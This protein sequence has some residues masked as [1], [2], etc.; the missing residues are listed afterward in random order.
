MGGRTEA[1]TTQPL[2]MTHSKRRGRSGTEACEGWTTDDRLTNE[3]AT[4]RTFLLQ[5]LHS[6]SHAYAT[7][8]LPLPQPLRNT[9]L[10]NLVVSVAMSSRAPPDP[11]KRA[12]QM[13]AGSQISNILHPIA[14]V[15]KGV[16]RTNHSQ[17][18]RQAL[19]AT[20]V[21]NA[22]KREEEEA[23]AAEEPFKMARFRG[24]ESV[25]RQKSAEGTLGQG[26][27]RSNGDEPVSRRTVSSG[28]LTAKMGNLS[29][30]SQ[31]QRRNGPASAQRGSAP[32]RAG[33]GTSNKS[34]TSA[35]P[36][37]LQ[38]D[39]DE[40]ENLYGQQ[41]QQQQQYDDEGDEGD[42]SP[43]Q[44][45]DDE[46]QDE[47][48][49]QYGRQSQQQQPQYSSQPQGGRRP[50]QQQ[51]APQ[52][53]ED[54]ESLNGLMAGRT[55]QQQGYGGGN[56]GPPRGISSIR[57]PSQQHQQQQ[58]QYQQP[59]SQQSHYSDNS[60]NNGDRRSF[61]AENAKKVI[62]TSKQLASARSNHPDDYA[63]QQQGEFLSSTSSSSA[64]GSGGGGAGGGASIQKHNDYG[65]VPQYIQDG[66]ARES[67]RRAREAEEESRKALG[68]PEGM[69]LMGEEQRL[70]T[71]AVLQENHR[72]ILLEISAFPLRVETISRKK[73]K[74]DLEAKLEEI[75][76]ALQ[77]FSRKR[78]LIQP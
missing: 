57:V 52:Y 55:Q 11:R 49:Q 10:A 58:Q 7:P 40:E 54:E 69:V 51:Q 1:S 6:L 73:A 29:M 22:L 56:G 19:K 59:P 13:N 46:E 25:L 21:R 67:E 33:A 28:G 30:S 9:P 62:Q 76:K 5:L 16:V 43:R 38:Y 37:R 78:V 32:P 41:Q 74:A 39:E 4:N 63:G 20:Q 65:R 3:F 23:K 31:Q 26:I 27:A 18:N 34:A 15:P 61:I 71:L 53:D 14:S 72:K 17:N 66:R 77:L 68:V 8:P 64:Y 70:Q 48:V 44:Q 60:N 35:A 47:S 45:Y 24:V 50:P 36:Q 12:L 2:S 75:E 42:F